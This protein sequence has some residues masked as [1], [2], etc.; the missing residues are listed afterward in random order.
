MASPHTAGLLAYLL[1]IYPSKTFNTSLPNFVPPAL[2]AGYTSGVPSVSEIYTRVHS[3][4]PGWVTAAL[5][6][7]ALFAA[8]QAPVPV[9]AI[10]PAQL[11]KA[12]IALGTKDVLS[13]STL[14]KDTPNILAFN[15]ATDARGKAW[16]AE[17]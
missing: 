9:P 3:Y 17:L 14:P 16:W 1:S 8:H 13:A 7:P 2:D 5:P 10:T 15:N 12:L 6:P 11:K 4:L